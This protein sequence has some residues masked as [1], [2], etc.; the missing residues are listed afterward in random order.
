MK[1][2]KASDVEYLIKRSEKFE[3]ECI[4]IIT[5]FAPELDTID[6]KIIACRIAMLRVDME[7]EFIRE[8]LDDIHEILAEDV[9]ERGSL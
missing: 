8:L 6:K 5:M 4:K 3:E 7:N 2:V 9:T 1:K